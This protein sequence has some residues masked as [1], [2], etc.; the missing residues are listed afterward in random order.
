[1]THFPVD[2]SLPP[3]PALAAAVIRL[4]LH[5][6]RI[7]GA[8]GESARR[9]LS[10]SDGL[11]FWCDVANVPT[12]MILARAREVVKGLDVGPQMRAA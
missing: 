9:F 5:D 8:R 10:G 2:A 12:A 7:R 3:Y 11:A 4:A 1:M 6:A